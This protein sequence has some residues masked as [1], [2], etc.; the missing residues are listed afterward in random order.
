IPSRI[1]KNDA[2]GNFDGP[3]IVVKLQPALTSEEVFERGR[4][5]CVARNVAIGKDWTHGK[6]TETMAGLFPEP[7]L[8]ADVKANTSNSAPTW[9]VITKSYHKLAVAQDMLQP[10]G[11]DLWKHRKKTADQKVQIYIALKNTIPASKYASW[12]QGPEVNEPASSQTEEG[13]NAS[14]ISDVEDDESSES[15]LNDDNDIST[16][17][18]HSK[19]SDSE[20]PEPPSPTQRCV[21]RKYEVIS[22][23]LEPEDEEHAIKKQKL[24]KGKAIARYTPPGNN[25]IASTSDLSLRQELVDLKKL[26]SHLLS[27]GERVKREAETAATLKRVSPPA[28]STH[29]SPWQSGYKCPSPFDTYSYYH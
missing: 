28:Y 13:A 22:D 29:I 27:E 11:A 18:D 26:V 14:V 15:V 20:T 3:K 12:Y 25:S 4:H 24:N 1:S 21:K 10:T 2:V 17:S 9:F 23:G 5:G 8:E 19:G 16:F 6:A 7:F